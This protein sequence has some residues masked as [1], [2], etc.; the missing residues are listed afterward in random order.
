MPD[1]KKSNVARQPF[2]VNEFRRSTQGEH[3]ESYTTSAAAQPQTYTDAT[4]AVVNNKAL[5]TNIA[6]LTTAAA[7]GFAVGQTVR[8]SIGDAVF[9][10]VRTIAT[11]PTSTTFTFERVNAN[12]GT[13]AVSPTGV[14]SVSGD[15]T[16]VLQ[17]GV[18]MAKITSGG[19]SGKI[20]PFQAGVSDGR[21]TTANIVGINGTP[22]MWELN[23]GDREIAVHQAGILVQA[24][25]IEYD[26][27]GFPIPLS[28]TTRDAILALPL[29]NLVSF[30]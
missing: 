2:G 1:F 25:C 4:T 22:L 24:W 9:D 5:T 8:I 20:G 6:T 15:A 13:V 17:P 27:A 7:H 3:T 29:L 28:N 21:Q 30:R 10:G 19:E 12:V 26:A 18:V 14:A 11:V 23:E 16:K